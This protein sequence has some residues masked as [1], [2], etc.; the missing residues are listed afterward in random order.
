VPVSQEVVDAVGEAA[1][2]FNGIGPVELKAVA[3]SVRVDS[4]S[5]S[6]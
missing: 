2:S 3:G 6:S 1:A 5:R 4:A